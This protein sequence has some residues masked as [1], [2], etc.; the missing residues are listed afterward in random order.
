MNFL[1]HAYLSFN[2]PQ[3]LVGNMISDF[4]KGKAQYD[5][6]AQIQA[7]IRLHRE[8][9]AFTDEH[10]ATKKA[11][12]IFRADYR[13]YSGALMDILYDHFLAT[14]ESIF[15]SGELLNFSTSVYAILDAQS[16]YLPQRF[17]TMLPYMK[18]ENWLL[19][20]ATKEGMER[21]L[22]G[23]VRRAVFISDHE[24][25]FRLFNEHY[26]FLKECYENFIGDVKNHSL[27][28]FKQLDL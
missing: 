2:H 23:I 20:Y 22:R 11:K 27:I 4:V 7:G 13:L 17:V 24:P 9:D 16:L 19:N 25:A 8:I 28:I 3:V 10:Y 1:A 21:S 5:Y 26:L 12:E 6:P 15:K 14:D 18:N